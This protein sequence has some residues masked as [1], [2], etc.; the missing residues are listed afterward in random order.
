MTTKAD[1][2]ILRS[3]EI[4]AQEATNAGALG[5]MGRALVQATLP[6]R[7]PTGSEFTRRNGDMILCITAPSMIG[8]PYGSI[9]RLLLAWLT[10]EAVKTQSR[11]LELGD[12]MS[13]FMAELGLVPTG[14]RFGSIPRLKKQA[15]RLF[16][17]TITAIHD[18]KT[19]QRRALKNLS[20]A[21]G[22]VLWWEP[23][24]PD[25]TSL[26]G[27]SVILSQG[28]FDEV[29]H[30]PV[31]IDMR[32]LRALKQSPMALDAYC[33]LTYRMSYLSKPTTIPWAALQLQFGS[34]Y[35]DTRFF[36]REFVNR[37]KGVSVVYPEARIEVS[38][39]GLILKPSRP[40]VPKTS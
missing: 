15:E 13:G 6:H 16:S 20:I 11:E 9:P 36:K 10:S 8:L 18:D 1:A 25:Q 19:H 21:D 40:H 32:A 33:W 28:F 14:G 39:A 4:E 3:L 7:K 24:I 30:N 38:D 29:T 5:F 27:S 31:P 37:L 12:S 26:W 22:A 23:R 17:S 35:S 2:L 34:D